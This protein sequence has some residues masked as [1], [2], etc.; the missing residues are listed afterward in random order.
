MVARSLLERL[1][2]AAQPPAP[3]ELVEIVTGR[4]A[5][6]QRFVQLQRGAQ[7]ES[8]G[9]AKPP[10]AQ[11]A[12][13][14]NEVAFETLAR[15]VRLRAIYDPETLEIPGQLDALRAVA[16]A[17]E[18]ARILPGLPMKLNVVD[19]RIG[20]IPLHLTERQVDGAIIVHASPL[21]DAITL[22]FDV[23]WERAAPVRFTGS[24]H[25]G[26]ARTPD[27]L[28]GAD[29]DVLVLLTA[30]LKETAIAQQL[31]VGKSTVERRIRRL[32]TML[33]ART[34]FQAGLQAANRGWIGPASTEQD[35]M[36]KRA[37]NV[38]R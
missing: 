30:G 18:E 1:R 9:F 16:E 27:D 17:G 24:Q 20:L 10:F 33:G 13:Q 38:I 2:R 3:V 29:Q 34:R 26:R 8:L 22:L 31:G 37:D 23:L 19:G 7:R 35:E 15:G 5:V 21:L 32:M 28:S 36:D 6:A 11:Q 4:E 14:Q 12:A 25:P